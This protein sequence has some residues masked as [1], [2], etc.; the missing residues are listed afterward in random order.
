MTME[1][2]DVLIAEDHEMQRRFLAERLAE[3][4]P[5]RVVGT[6]GDGVEA[7]GM[8]IALR[9]QVLVLDMVMPKMDG[10][11]L[12][13][14]L[15]RI[16]DIP[17]PAIIALTTLNREDFIQR[18][19]NLC[20]SYYMVKPVDP[21]QLAR[22][23][24]FLAGEENRPRPGHKSGEELV[25]D[26][27]VQL[28]VP[29]NLLGY[30]CLRAALGV[31]CSEPRLIKSLSHGLY[32]RVAQQQGMS[33]ESVERAIRHAITQ[34]WSRGGEERYHQMLGRSGSLVGDKPTNG[35][36]LAQ[37]SECLRIQLRR[38]KENPDRRL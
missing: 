15:Q 38:Q 34:T 4:P 37:V 24:Q 23:I 8:V 2:I 18:A 29:A 26:M 30:R 27:L 12:M 25:R 20:V 14:Q 5:I 6:A 19:L 33:A 28:G 9:P 36:F 11:A 17:H 13:E 3:Y 1:R 16:S 10:F 35:E 31:L 21:E 32:P 7:L 22:R